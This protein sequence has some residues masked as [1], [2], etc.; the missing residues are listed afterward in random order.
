[1][2]SSLPSSGLNLGE[3]ASQTDDGAV[4]IT[5]TVSL[6]SSNTFHS[7]PA[8]GQGSTMLDS[9]PSEAGPRAD[10]FVRKKLSKFLKGKEEEWTAVAQRKGPLQL[11]DL[12]MDVLKEIVKEV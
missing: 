11:L 5:K 8:G 2:T 9:L 7:T 1:M 3:N 4:S 6:T 12:P 10:G